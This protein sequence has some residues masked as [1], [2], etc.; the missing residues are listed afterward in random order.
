MRY[1]QLSQSGRQGDALT[2]NLGTRPQML[3]Y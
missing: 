2:D 3:M 1:L